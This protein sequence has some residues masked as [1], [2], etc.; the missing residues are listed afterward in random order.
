MSG[1]YRSRRGAFKIG[2][3]NDDTESSEEEEERDSRSFPVSCVFRLREMHATPRG[4]PR[5]DG[6]HR[7]PS[8]R[9][10]VAASTLSIHAGA[11]RER[12]LRDLLVPALHRVFYHAPR[13]IREATR[14]ELPGVRQHVGDGVRP[15]GLVPCLPVF[16]TVSTRRARTLTV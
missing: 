16:S 1:A 10:A 2:T 7:P 8:P 4:P 14:P 9:Y 15:A 3:I 13:H 5:G 6:V 11:L 12:V